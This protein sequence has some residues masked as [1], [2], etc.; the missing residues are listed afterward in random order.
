MS[1]AWFSVEQGLPG[2]I[3]DREDHQAG[4]VCSEEHQQLGLPVRNVLGAL[5]AAGRWGHLAETHPASAPR[6]PTPLP[7]FTMT[8]VGAHHAL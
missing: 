1:S 2:L 4:G 8:S 3:G 7:S 5:V 6:S